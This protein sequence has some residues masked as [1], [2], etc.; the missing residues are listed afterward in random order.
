MSEIVRER[1]TVSKEFVGMRFQEYAAAV[2][3]TIPTRAGVKKA[4][5]RGELRIDGIAAETGRYMQSGMVIELYEG[6]LPA[7]K[8]FEVDLPIL[9]EDEFLAVVIKPAG[10][11]VSGN[12]FKTVQNGLSGVISYSNE[13]DALPVPRPVHRLDALTTGVLVI[14]KTIKARIELGRLFEERKIEKEYHAIVQGETDKF[15][16]MR[17][18]I[19]EKECFSEYEKVN[20]IPSLKSGTLTLLKLI[21]HTGRTHQLRIHCAESGF[22]IAGDTVHGDKNH[23]ILHKGLFLAATKIAF[24]HPITNEKLTFETELPTKFTRYWD[25]ELKRYEK[26]ADSE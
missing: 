25:G 19:S 2:V 7:S 24:T 12:R 8:R 17:F 21:P 11:P 4:I 6:E 3:E 14:A 23:T 5:K 13:P 1:H 20:Q 16:E 9:F 22:P 26:Y 15:G 18:P 10:I